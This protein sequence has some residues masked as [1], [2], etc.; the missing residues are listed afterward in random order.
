MTNKMKR[1]EPPYRK[2]ELVKRLEYAKDDLQCTLAKK[3]R[4][5]DYGPN[6]SSVEMSDEALKEEVEELIKRLKI[7]LH[8]NM[9]LDILKILYFYRFP[10][11]NNNTFLKPLQNNLMIKVG[12]RA[13]INSLKFWRRLY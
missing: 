7:P 4:Q 6:I 5:R 12:A 10:R 2:P 13:Q 3:Q 9:F 8:Q 11:L 1:K